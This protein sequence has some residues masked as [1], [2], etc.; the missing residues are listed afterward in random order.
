MFTRLKD[1]ERELGEDSGGEAE[2]VPEGDVEY[3]GSLE[4]VPHAGAKS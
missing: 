2:N 4:D 1:D 3:L